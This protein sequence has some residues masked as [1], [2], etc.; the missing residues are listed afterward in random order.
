[1]KRN[2]KGV[3]LVIL[4]CFTFLFAV[5][6]IFA[7]ECKEC[8]SFA[9]G[10]CTRYVCEKRKEHLFGCVA[11]S[12]HAGPWLQNAKNVGY[13]TEDIPAPGAILVTSESKY[14]HVAFVEFVDDS[15]REFKVSEMNYEGWGKVSSRTLSYDFS[16]IKGFIYGPTIE[17]DGKA[18]ACWAPRYVPCEN[19][20]KW[21]RATGL[22]TYGQAPAV[23]TDS[24]ICSEIAQTETVIEEAP[25]PNKVVPDEPWWQACWRLF[26]K[27][28]WPFNDVEASFEIHASDANSANGFSDFVEP[29]TVIEKGNGQATIISGN[30]TSASDATGQGY[31]SPAIDESPE[32]DLPDFTEYDLKL[33][34]DNGNERYTYY[35]YD[36][37]IEMHHWSTNIGEADWAGDADDIYVRFY[38]SKGY[39]ARNGADDW[40]RVGSEQI[41]KGNLDI[42]DVKH[43][44]AT[45]DIREKFDDGYFEHDGVY[46]IVVCIDREKDTNN[47]DGEVPEMH[48]SNN[49][50]SEAVFTFKEYPIPPAERE[51]LVALYDST[52]GP[53]WTNKNG[54]KIDPDP[55]MWHG[56]TVEYGRVTGLNLF[57]NNLSGS[58]PPKIGELENLKNLNLGDKYGYE[59][60]NGLSGPI[61][62]ELGNLTRLEYLNLSW[63]ELI[64]GQIPSSIQNF[65]RSLRVLSLDG[66]DLNG[67]FPVWLANLVNLTELRLDWTQ[68]SGNVPTQIQNLNTLTKLYLGFNL[69]G[70]IPEWIGNLTNLTELYLCGGLTGEIPSSIGELTNL[71]E[72]YLHSNE[73]TGEIPSSFG[74][75]GN[76]A[77]LSLS[78]NELIGEI[79]EWIGNLTSLRHL[80]LP[81]NLLTGQIPASLGNLTNLRYLSLSQNQLSG[82]IPTS[83]GNLGNL[84][85]LY[86][87]QNQLS[88]QIPLSIGLLTNLTDLRLGENQLTGTIPPEIGNMTN[89]WSLHLD[90]NQLTGVI[91][92]TLANLQ[93]LGWLNLYSNRITALPP[94]LSQNLSW[95][96]VGDNNLTFKSLEPYIGYPNLI[97]FTYSPQAKIRVS[98]NTHLLNQGKTLTV[99]VDVGGE[100]NQYQWFK[101]STAVSSISN[102]PDYSKTNV[103]K[104]DSGTYVCHITNTLVTDLILYTENITVT[105]TDDGLTECPECSSSPVNLTTVTFDSDT[106]CRCSDDISITIGKGVT[107]KNGTTVV[108]DAP[109]V[110]VKSGVHFERGANVTIKQE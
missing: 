79:P 68:L 105:V 5:G 63:N 10:N 84:D 46:N 72:L 58:I 38:L 29:R 19:A 21:F 49:C 98:P 2:I 59:G 62:P 36:D 73:L 52:N 39:K 109:T 64:T 11:W 97:S 13:H 4:V 31:Q 76:L 96:G 78:Y 56:V 86:L 43:E 94:N 6:P 7:Y 35:L 50:S 25:D 53:G 48:K 12:G 66:C 55:R 51:V 40:V 45:L 34:D 85:V 24:S 18:N 101:D 27:T 44:W 100:H 3:G 104:S 8:N 90:Y 32:P 108:F 80:S 107:V 42:G 95:F 22:P 110:N 87:Y 60:S 89:L 47:G 77:S 82:R 81:G 99:T 1:M 37:E 57:N 67:P 91:P 54:W 102:D 103:S 33:M 61:P 70:E 75:L 16:K 69:T 41:K 74:N 28:I 23:S 30:G 26:R 17:V 71:N 93:D 14:G 15:K 83:L 65:G 106:P 88:G 92:A 9:E 20:Q